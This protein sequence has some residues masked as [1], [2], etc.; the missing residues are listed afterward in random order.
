MVLL[1]NLKT[2][3]YIFTH[4][5]CV[6]AGTWVNSVIGFREFVSLILVVENQILWPSFIGVT[7]PSSPKNGFSY[8]KT[9]IFESQ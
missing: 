7:Q 9:P 1:Q 2:P 6:P 3:D 5:V 4:S 8:V